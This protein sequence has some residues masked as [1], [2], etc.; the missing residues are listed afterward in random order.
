M[1]T[2]ALCF[3]AACLL[4]TTANAALESRLGGLAVY[5]TDLNVTWLA[6]AH[7][8]LTNT[9]GLTTDVDLGSI[10]GVNTEGGSYIWGM[11][12]MTW[13]GAMKWIT[14]MN[15]ANY[16]GYNDWRLPIVTDGDPLAPFSNNGVGSGYNKTGSEMAHLFYNELGNKGFLSPDG[17]EQVDSSYGLLNKGPFTNFQSAYWSGTEY[18]DNGAWYFLTFDGMQEYTSK[19]W[20]LSALVVRPGD[21]P[22]VCDQTCAATTTPITP[23][24][25]PTAA[26]M[27][28]S[29][30]LGLMAVTRR[31]TSLPGESA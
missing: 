13:G 15:T 30:L 8:A 16:L 25:L 22:L 28:G 18:S 6:D 12:D 5:D 2:A 31:K 19:R 1:K 23:T 7:L 21:V 9:F 17:V 3:A 11:G 20:S 27:L 4:S 10:P 29:G 26:W 24:P 14:A